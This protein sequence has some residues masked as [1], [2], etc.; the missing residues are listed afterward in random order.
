MNT[1]PACDI[2]K[3]MT[4]FLCICLLLLSGCTTVETTVGSDGS[5]N[6]LINCLSMSSCEEKAK[7][8]CK[9][10]Y[11]VISTQTHD[12]EDEDTNYDLL[13]KCGS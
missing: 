8:L 10:P 11:K 13:I 3:T 9:G 4:Q 1:S 7:S 6:H 12:E 2:R 5:A